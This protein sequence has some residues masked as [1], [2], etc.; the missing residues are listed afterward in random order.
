MRFKLRQL[1]VGLLF[2]V[3]WLCGANSDYVQEIETARTTRL[4]SLTHADGWLTLIGR[5]PLPSGRA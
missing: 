1:L 5:L 3:S 2:S 4:D